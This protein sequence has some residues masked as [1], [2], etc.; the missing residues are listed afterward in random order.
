MS[1][2]KSPEDLEPNQAE[3]AQEALVPKPDEQIVTQY[4]PMTEVSALYP[5]NAYIDLFHQFSGMRKILSKLNEYSKEINNNF[6][7]L[8]S[9]GAALY[10]AV[11]YG[12]IEKLIYQPADFED[13]IDK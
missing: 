2:E 5:S 13:F 8:D 10:R 6:L 3:S 9:D 12:Y 7:K 4:I 11:M 1:A